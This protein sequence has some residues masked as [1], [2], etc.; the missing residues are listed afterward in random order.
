MGYNT[1][2]KPSQ[3]EENS[4]SE[5]SEGKKWPNSNPI[6]ILKKTKKAISQ[7]MNKITVTDTTKA[8]GS[9]ADQLNS[10]VERFEALEESIKNQEKRNLEENTHFSSTLEVELRKNT[11]RMQVEVESIGRNLEI[12][13]KEQRL[14]T[15]RDSYRQ[16]LLVISV[17]SWCLLISSAPI[18]FNMK[19]FFMTVTVTAVGIVGNKYI[20][21]KIKAEKSSYSSKVTFPVTFENQTVEKVDE[22]EID[23]NFSTKTVRKSSVSTY[24][25]DRVISSVVVEEVK[26]YETTEKELKSE[27]KNKKSLKLDLNEDLDIIQTK[28][29]DKETLKGMSFNYLQDSGIKFSISYDE[30]SEEQQDLFDKFKIKFEKVLKNSKNLDKTKEFDKPDDFNLLRYLEADKYNIKLAEK[31]L[32]S[33]IEFRQNSGIINY[34]KT[35]PRDIDIYK[36]LRP[37][38]TWG[39][40]KNCRPVIYENVGMFFSNKLVPK[41]LSNQNWIKCYAYEFQ[42]YFLEFRKASIKANKNIHNFTFIADCSK[43]KF[44]NLR[45]LGIINTLKVLETHI[46]EVVGTIYVINVPSFA[47]RA[48]HMISKLLDPTLASKFRLIPPNKH[49]N[50]LIEE[51]GKEVVPIVYGGTNDIKLPS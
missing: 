16:S 20:N 30:L 21:M 10:T 3:N 38:V 17:L 42:E 27:K 2:E 6:N 22:N 37:R 44:G 29:L 15:L 25:R 31:R 28:V 40:D 48:W 32:L 43:C 7:G 19:V 8:L 39:L 46:P 4:D 14:H 51:L 35:L 23:D 36:Q 45:K 1:G 18:D 11:Q 41:G 47:A 24:S 50:I 12:L 13:I 9:I 33:T 26:V 5:S 49:S 34:P